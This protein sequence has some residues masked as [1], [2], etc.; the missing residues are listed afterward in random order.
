MKT[1][2]P[3]SI[4][5]LFLAFSAFLVGCAA[6]SASTPDRQDRIPEETL[7]PELEKVETPDA[8]P[9]LGEVPDEILEKI[10]A[11]LL[12][13]TNN[14]R[15]SVDVLRAQS[16]IWNDGSLGCPQ[17][18]EFYTQSLVEGYWVL[19]KAGEREYDYRASETGYFFL[20]EGGLPPVN[21]GD[22]SSPKQ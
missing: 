2:Q 3:L 7:P 6:E 19:L 9:I 8:D 21:P 13:R 15:E 1:Y 20:C 4:F 5:L 17:P 22:G 12:A 18:G 16:V 11:D 10:I 14:D